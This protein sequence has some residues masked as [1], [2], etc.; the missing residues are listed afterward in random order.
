MRHLLRSLTYFPHMHLVISTYMQTSMKFSEIPSQAR[1]AMHSCLWMI[2]LF[3]DPSE[4]H[5]SIPSPCPSLVTQGSQV[6]IMSFTLYVPS[7]VHITILESLMT[8][9]WTTHSLQFLLFQYE[10]MICR[11]VNYIYI[12]SMWAKIWNIV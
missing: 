1:S 12:L 3:C 6:D 10:S 4:L 9:F 8:I 2:F 7:H 11:S 5:L